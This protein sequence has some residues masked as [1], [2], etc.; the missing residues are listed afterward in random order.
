MTRHD[1]PTGHP[2]DPDRIDIRSIDVA[3][4]TCGAANVL[5]ACDCD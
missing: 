3:C 5:W 1:V 2:D 4:P